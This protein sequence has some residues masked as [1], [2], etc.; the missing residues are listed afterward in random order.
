MQKSFTPDNI[1]GDAAKFVAMDIRTA[2]AIMTALDELTSPNALTSD[3][4]AWKVAEWFA[5]YATFRTAWVDAPFTTSA[6]L[7]LR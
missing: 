1:D 6:T 5:A 3:E 4:D 7:K 2:Y